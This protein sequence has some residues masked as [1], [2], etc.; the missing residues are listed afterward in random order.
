MCEV[1]LGTG[2]TK[3]NRTGSAF[4]SKKAANNPLVRTEF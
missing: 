3:M 4:N 2:Y 1:L